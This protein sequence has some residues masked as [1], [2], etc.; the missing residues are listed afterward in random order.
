M[1]FFNDFEEDAVSLPK[2]NS[3]IESILGEESKNY[4]DKKEALEFLGNFRL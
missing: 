2:M 4:R 1:K 3:V